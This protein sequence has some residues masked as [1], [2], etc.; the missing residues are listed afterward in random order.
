MTTNFT[1]VEEGTWRGELIAIG[2]LHRPAARVRRRRRAGPLPGEPSALE[3][4]TVLGWTLVASA[5]VVWSTM[6]LRHLSRSKR[7]KI[8]PEQG[9]AR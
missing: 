1:P 8:P 4:T 7:S 9:D 3:A 6:R 2:V 5:S